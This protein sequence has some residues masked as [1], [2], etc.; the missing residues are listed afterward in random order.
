MA[1]NPY[2][3]LSWQSVDTAD[4]ANDSELPST[5]RLCS[6]QRDCCYTESP[7][8]GKCSTASSSRSSCSTASSS[9]SSCSPPRPVLSYPANLPLRSRRP[10]KSQLAFHA[11]DANVHKCSR[12]VSPVAFWALARAVD[13]LCSGVRAS[14]SACCPAVWEPHRC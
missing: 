4:T 10:S 11:A 13:A 12:G 2:R 6:R 3:R 7:S 5:G 1:W 14:A 8:P 9:R